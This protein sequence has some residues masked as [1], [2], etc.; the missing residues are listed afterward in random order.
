M[1]ILDTYLD[2][3]V[4]CSAQ[5]QRLFFNQFFQPPPLGAVAEVVVELL[6]T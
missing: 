2:T 4:A 1:P 5:C 3:F 6:L